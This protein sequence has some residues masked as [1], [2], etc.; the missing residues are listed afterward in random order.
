MLKLLAILKI[1]SNLHLQIRI[2]SD[3]LANR[4]TSQAQYGLPQVCRRTL[5][6]T[7][8][9]NKSLDAH[10]EMKATFTIWAIGEMLLYDFNFVN[11]E[12]PINI[13]MKTSCCLKTIHSHFLN[14]LALTGS[15]DSCGSSYYKFCSF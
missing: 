3:R 6:C 15:L 1:C 5:D 4:C 2:E 14:F 8:F 12:F 7:A 10:V 13:K 11:A 9:M